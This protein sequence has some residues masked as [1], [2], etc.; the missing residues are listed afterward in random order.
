MSWLKLN[1]DTLFLMKG[2][3]KTYIDKVP[4]KEASIDTK[5]IQVIENFPGV[6]FESIQ[7]PRTIVVNTDKSGEKTKSFSDLA[8]LRMLAVPIDKHFFN[9]MKK[10]KNLRDLIQ[11]F[12]EL[13][14]DY[15]D[16]FKTFSYSYQKGDGSEEDIEYKVDFLRYQ[17]SIEASRASITFPDGLF[18]PR[19]DIDISFEN[20]AFADEILLPIINSAGLTVRPSLYRFSSPDSDNPKIGAALDIIQQPK[21]QL[22]RPVTTLETL[23]KSIIPKIYAPN[24]SGNSPKL[25]DVKLHLSERWGISINNP[26]SWNTREI[27]LVLPD[28]ITFPEIMDEICFL[29]NA[30]WDW[31]G[32]KRVRLISLDD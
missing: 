10:K 5:N 23:E 7:Y 3:D 19:D 4:I 9:E 32:P 21:P 13:N 30:T 26:S 15:S 20:P 18:P 16:D 17:Y 1:N 31:F 27:S 14:G 6:W 29:L 8:I 24:G 25:S 12:N 22:R 11:V 2:G 28:L